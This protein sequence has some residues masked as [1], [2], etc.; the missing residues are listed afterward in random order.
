VEGLADGA[1]AKIVV[2]SGKLTFDRKAGQFSQLTIN[3]RETREGAPTAPGFDL[4]S[5]LTSRI[6]VIA[7]P[8]ELSAAKLRE[9]APHWAPARPSTQQLDFASVASE[10]GGRAECYALDVAD[11]VQ[12]AE[13]IA[14]AAQR[15][16]PVDVLVNSAG[17]LVDKP[18][19]QLTAREFERVVSVNLTGTFCVGQ[20]V[21]RTMTGRGGRIINIASVGGLLGYP[22]RA[23]YAASKGAVIAL[24]RVM[25]VELAPHGILVNAVAPGPVHT[26]MTANVYDERF[27][28]GMMRRVPL[29]RMATPREI[30]DVAVFLASE[31][32]SYITGQ[33]IAVDGGMSIAGM[34]AQARATV[35]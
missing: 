14:K 10:I 11:P 22:G 33:T 17:V 24:T 3:F 19:L 25:A 8:A 30:A 34:T 20:A 5:K 35:V 4:S 27:R 7:E 26:A 15:L 13:C 28:A 2:A 23:A 29:A 6:A 9:V 21:A 31:A 12:V 16:G 1:K 18:F 32:A